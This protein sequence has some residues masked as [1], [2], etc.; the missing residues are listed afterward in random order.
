MRVS[1][2]AESATSRSPTTNVRIPISDTP[3]VQASRST[4]EHVPHPLVRIP[5]S[6]T[7]SVQASRS[8]IERAP[9]PH[10]SNVRVPVEVDTIPVARDLI[11]WPDERADMVDANPQSK[12]VMCRS[13]YVARSERRE[14]DARQPQDNSGSMMQIL[15]GDQDLHSTV[16]QRANADAMQVAKDELAQRDEAQRQRDEA[17]HQRNED[18]R[19]RDE[20]QLAVIL[21]LQAA[22]SAMN[23]RREV[24]VMQHTDQVRW[25]NRGPFG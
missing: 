20:V 23:N 9:L 6:D 2:P 19:R 7:P 1:S 15:R 8:T 11:S 10:I 24:S 4:I 18:Q 3:C 13:E 17:Q 25:A 5:I 14:G 12:G 16:Q 21:D 22:V